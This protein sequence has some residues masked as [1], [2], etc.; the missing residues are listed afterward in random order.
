MSNY[1]V[2]P[3]TEMCAECGGYCCKHMGCHYSPAD[4]S[5]LS[6]EALKSQIE[7]GRIS[8]DWWV[9]GGTREYY[10]RARHVGEPV[11]KGSWGGRCVNLTDTG[12]S[13]S[14]EE[15]PLGG[16]ALKPQDRLGGGCTTSYSKEQCKDDWKPY[17]VV[18]EELVKYFGEEKAS[19]FAEMME[20]LG[21]ITGRCLDGLD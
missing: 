8:I 20:A 19:P 5:D 11:V 3:P 18:L 16:K 21:A 4:F 17:T 6:F 15:R 12:C 9:S 1:P 13:L 14:W 7:K 2:Y 10:L